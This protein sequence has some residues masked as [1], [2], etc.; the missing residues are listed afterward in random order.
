MRPKCSAAFYY[1]FTIDES[2]R[3]ACVLAKKLHTFAVEK[4]PQNKEEE[5]TSE[6]E[7]VVASRRQLPPARPRPL[8]K[9]RPRGQWYYRVPRAADASKPGTFKRHPTQVKQKR[10]AS[11]SRLITP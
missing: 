4:G 1:V 5:E 7:V 3:S 2:V 9:R 10:V 8:H 6:T 11:I